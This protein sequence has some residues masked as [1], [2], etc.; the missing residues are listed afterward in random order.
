MIKTT[1]SARYQAR[2]SSLSVS[3]SISITRFQFQSSCG[4]GDGRAISYQDNFCDSPVI[5]MELL[6]LLLL[7]ANL[8][9]LET[10][11]IG[12]ASKQASKRP[13]IQQL[14]V[15]RRPFCIEISGRQI[16][17][18]S[19][20]IARAIRHDAIRRSKFGLRRPAARRRE[21][22]DTRMSRNRGEIAMTGRLLEMVSAAF[23]AT[24]IALFVL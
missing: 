10:L 3:V 4:C 11:A 21:S 18:S 24:V 23:A 20:R 14:A 7:Q 5:M 15:R 6:L 1:C 19:S 13:S 12:Q 16:V 22:S 8:P 17:V 2:I 9:P